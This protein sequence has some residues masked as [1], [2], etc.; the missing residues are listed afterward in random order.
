MNIAAYTE[1]KYLSRWDLDG[2]DLPIIGSVT[3]YNWSLDLGA[4]S[5]ELQLQGKPLD[6]NL[7]WTTGAFLQFVHPIG[8]S[9]IAEN[10]FNFPGSP[11]SPARST[12]AAHARFRA[13][14]R[15]MCRP[16][17]IWAIC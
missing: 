17:I 9:S 8:Y 10:E 3:P 7:N 16:A 6:G 12:A 4:A 2:S 13:N 15:S 14:R 5:E 11:R 1:S